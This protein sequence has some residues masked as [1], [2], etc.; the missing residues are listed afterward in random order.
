MLVELAKGYL[1]KLIIFDRFNWVAFFVINF[2]VGGDY[3]RYYVIKV[4][5]NDER[6]LNG[7][8]RKEDAILQMNIQGSKNDYDQGRI[9]NRRHIA[10]Y[11]KWARCIS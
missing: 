6:I 5:G 7:Y 4:K 9:K 1:I 11:N 2:F 8:D 10:V 3:V